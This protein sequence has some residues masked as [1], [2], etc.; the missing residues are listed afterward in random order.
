MSNEIVAKRYAV[1]L[2]QLAKEKNSIEQI[3]NDL[4]VIKEIFT[5]NKDLID[6]LKHPKVTME[7]KKSIVK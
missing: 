1:A 4:S 3:E 2:F 7:S 6:V 5:S